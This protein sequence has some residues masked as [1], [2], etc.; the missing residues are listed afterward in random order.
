MVFYA[1]IIKKLH[2]NCYSDTRV[3]KSASLDLYYHEISNQLHRKISS[4]KKQS[5]HFKLGVWVQVLGR[6]NE[7]HIWPDI[8][9]KTLKFIFYSNTDYLSNYRTMKSSGKLHTVLW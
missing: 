5:K 6:G 2:L 7:N 1:Y 3:Y 4:F 9:V 8:K